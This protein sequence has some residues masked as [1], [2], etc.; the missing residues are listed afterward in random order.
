MFWRKVWKIIQCATWMLILFKTTK[1]RY[2][3]HAHT[4]NSCRYVSLHAHHKQINFT[5]SSRSLLC[6]SSHEYIQPISTSKIQAALSIYRPT[7]T[8]SAPIQWIFM[9]YNNEYSWVMTID[10]QN[11]RHASHWKK[12]Y[13][14]IIKYKAIATVFFFLP[15]CLSDPLSIARYKRFK[16]NVRWK[17]IE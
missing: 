12:R 4:L 11:D 8:D 3:I 17:K 10:I 14:C 6:T 5:H 13:V 1:Q 7:H 2:K 16:W 15:D 9:N